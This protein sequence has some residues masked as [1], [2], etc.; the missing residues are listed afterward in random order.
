[1]TGL[2]LAQASTVGGGAV[3]PAPPPRARG[4]S[5]S[6]R[7][8]RSNSSSETRSPPPSPRFSG[9][10]RAVMPSPRALPLCKKCNAI[11]AIR[12]TRRRN[13]P[14]AWSLHRNRRSPLRHK[15]FH[16]RLHSSPR[17]ISLTGHRPRH[18]L[19]TTALS[20]ARARGRFLPQELLARRPPSFG[21]QPSGRSSRPCFGGI[22]ALLVR[23]GPFSGI[24]PRVVSSAARATRQAETSDSARAL[25]PCHGGVRPPPRRSPVALVQT[26]ALSEFPPT[27]LSAFSGGT[28]PSIEFLRPHV[29]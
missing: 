10:S 19:Q 26:A 1:M 7:P 15:A 3:R 13:S 16:P 9:C 17:S 8:Q 6:P 5:R 21:G 28:R 14:R 24:S 22:V 27:E 4:P 25:S 18:A 12:L 23:T 11:R 2:R 29:R 20:A